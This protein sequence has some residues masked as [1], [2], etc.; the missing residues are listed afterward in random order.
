MNIDVIDPDPESTT[1]I[2]ASPPITADDT[3]TFIFVAGEDD[4]AEVLEPKVRSG[5]YRVVVSF[6][7]NSGDFDIY[8]VEFD[9]GYAAMLQPSSPPAGST[10]SPSLSQQPE[11]GEQITGGAGAAAAIITPQEGAPPSL[12]PNIF[13]SNIDGI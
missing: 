7:E 5:N 8:E 12:P 2:Q 6:F 9:F 4:L 13:Q 11:S 10:A 1:V 3:F